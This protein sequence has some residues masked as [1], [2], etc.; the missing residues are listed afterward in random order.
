MELHI[1]KPTIATL[2]IE[3]THQPVQGELQVQ[4]LLMS[5]IEPM[6]SAFTWTT[7]VQLLAYLGGL[8]RSFGAIQSNQA[9]GG[10]GG[11]AAVFLSSRP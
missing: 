7:L 4:Q 8:W 3:L 9:L 10:E 11:S 1:A 6:P 5:L 2:A